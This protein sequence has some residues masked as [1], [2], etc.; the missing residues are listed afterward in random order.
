MS[1]HKTMAANYGRLLILIPVLLTVILGSQAIAE[2]AGESAPDQPLSEEDLQALDSSLQALKALAP[3]LRVQLRTVRRQVDFDPREIHRIERGMSQAQK[4]LQ[5][6]IAMSK[7]KAFNG[8]R[9][10][11]LADDLRRKSEGLKESLVYVG[12]RTQVSDKQQND[13]AQ[14]QNEESLLSL[15]GRYSE[16]VSA[17]VVLLQDRGI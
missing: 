2:E 10:H 8:M 1:Y 9:A 17:S 16:L 15:L 11:F 14:Q 6:L 5:R 7:R 3:K 12:E 4:D 13:P